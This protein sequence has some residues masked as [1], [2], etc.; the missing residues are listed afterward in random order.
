MEVCPCRR[1][2]PSTSRRNAGRASVNPGQGPRWLSWLVCPAPSGS[3]WHLPFLLPLA[4]C[5]DSGSSGKCRAIFSQN[6][7]REASMFFA[8]AGT[9]HH[10]GLPSVP[11]TGLWL[12]PGSYSSG[13]CSPG[14]CCQPTTYGGP[15]DPGIP[16]PPLPSRRPW[17]SCSL[18]LCP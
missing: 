8:A 15:V 9:E 4:Q 7:Q 16:A 6:T 5:R 2:G 10:P 13:L 1:A 11:C 17:P 18:N 14:P 12:S 3:S